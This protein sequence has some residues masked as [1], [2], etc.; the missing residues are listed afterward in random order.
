MGISPHLLDGTIG[1]CWTLRFPSDSIV[2][3]SNACIAFT[4]SPDAIKKLAGI[5]AFAP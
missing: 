2:S 5:D 3:G 1:V 4:N